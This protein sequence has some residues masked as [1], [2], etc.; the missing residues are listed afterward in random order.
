MKS[1]I[2]GTLGLISFVYLLNP[3]GGVIELIPDNFPVV[4]NLDEGA[5]ITLLIMSLRHFGIDVSR[6]FENKNPE[7]ETA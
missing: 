6:S 3:T 5:A 1:F 2:M 7:K 4:G